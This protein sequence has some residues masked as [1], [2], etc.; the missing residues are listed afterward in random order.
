MDCSRFEEVLFLYTDD[1]LEQEVVVLFQR[2]IELCPE[3]AQ[4]AVYTQRLLTIMWKCCARTTAP[5]HLR[6][7]ILASL[8]HRTMDD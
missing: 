8:P 6:R 4:R 2:H 1:Q 5:D 3:C 7:R